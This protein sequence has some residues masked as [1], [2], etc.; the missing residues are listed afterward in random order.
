MVTVHR[1]AALLSMLLAAACSNGDT[2]DAPE[3]TRR[4]LKRVAVPDSVAAL[5]PKDTL[6]LVR[7]ASR[8]ELEEALRRV[9]D[10]TRLPLESPYPALLSQFGI[11]VIDAPADQPL[12]VAVSAQGPTLI[13]RVP[14][15]NGYKGKTAERAGWRAL[16]VDGSYTPGE[17]TRTAMPSGAISAVVDLLA[18]RRVFASRIAGGFAQF[19]KTVAEKARQKLGGESFVA[20]FR[21]LARFARSHVEN[22]RAVRLAASLEDHLLHVDFEF[23][24]ERALSTAP[25]AGLA[26]GIPA[27]FPLVLAVPL[28]VGAFMGLYA[29]A[30][31]ET[32][33]GVATLSDKDR[34]T[35]GS[36]LRA[37]GAAADDTMLF[38]ADPIG[39]RGFLIALRG[40]RVREHLLALV[41][42]DAFYSMGVTI[43]EVDVEEVGGAVINRFELRLDPERFARAALLKNLPREVREMATK[44]V[45]FGVVGRGDDCLI[46]I[47]ATP[48]LAQAIA[49]QTAVHPCVAAA[50]RHTPG[51]IAVLGYLDLR[52]LGNSLTGLLALLDGDEVVGETKP[53]APAPIRL[54]GSTRGSTLHLNLRID[55]EEMR[56]LASGL[57]KT[58]P[59]GDR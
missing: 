52:P 9:R 51:D 21:R 48:D 31:S 28:D 23:E 8:T 24:S 57:P 35:I 7:F 27:D 11:A 13:A 42:S 49:G 59:G 33:R 12:F 17:S 40:A 18:V 50:Q 37:L 46:V 55:L 4:E 14:V 44:G 34:E 20:L 32:G 19:E 36:G 25:L 3:A 39:N 43:T 56:V 22:A 5:C 29:D 15:P 30:L 47:S 1:S 45:A 16:S 53:G 58:R 54:Q 26:R 2:P 6:V 10:A 41:R 38:A